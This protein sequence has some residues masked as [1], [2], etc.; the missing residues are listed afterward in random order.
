MGNIKSWN[1]GAELVLGYK[2]DEIIGKHVDIL[3][4]KGSENNS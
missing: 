1:R 2:K 4:A 3:F